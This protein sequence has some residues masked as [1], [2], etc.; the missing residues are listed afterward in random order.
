MSRDGR[1][2][3]SLIIFQMIRVIS[4]PSIST[5]GFLTL[6]LA[7]PVL[8][9]PSGFPPPLATGS[10]PPGAVRQSGGASQRVGWRLTPPEPPTHRYARTSGRLAMTA[11]SS[12]ERSRAYRERLRARGLREIRLIV[13]DLRNPR[14]REEIQRDFRL[15]KGH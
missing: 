15:L 4:S 8:H 6:I 14:V 1:I 10:R 2:S 9:T 11:M 12:A 3:L 5:T 7:T 13:L